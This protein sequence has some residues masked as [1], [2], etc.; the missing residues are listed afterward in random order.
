[1]DPHSENDPHRPA[2]RLNWTTI[3]LVGGLVALVLLIVYFAATRNPDQDKLV[4]NEVTEVQ[5]DQS[6][7]LCS[8]KATYDLI[9]RELFRRAAQL[10]GSD[11]AAYDQLA[12]VAVLRMDNAVMESEDGTTGAVNCSG[13]L[14]LDLPPGVAVPGGRRTLISDIDYAVQPGGNAVELRGADTIIAQLST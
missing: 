10:R 9:K 4:G 2:R 6:E 8:S 3:A 1:M 5:P 11:Q 7:K 13:S 12:A 14:S